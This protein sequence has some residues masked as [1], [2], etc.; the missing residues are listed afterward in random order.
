MGWLNL[1]GER[2][3]RQGIKGFRLSHRQ[4]AAWW[5]AERRPFGRDGRC[6]PFSATQIAENGEPEAPYNDRDHHPKYPNLP[7]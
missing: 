3:Q 1:D 6:G 2:R 4:G 5:R 7:P